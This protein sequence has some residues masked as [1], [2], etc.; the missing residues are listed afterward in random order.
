MEYSEM[1]VKQRAEYLLKKGVEAKMQIDPDRLAPGYAAHVVGIGM[2]SACGYHRS[3]QDAIEAGREYLLAKA[4]SPIAISRDPPI[5]CSHCW[6]DDGERGL[7]CGDKDWMASAESS[8]GVHVAACRRED[9]TMLSTP[10]GL[11]LLTCAAGEINRNA[12]QAGE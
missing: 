12:D 3:E 9:R 7:A 6:D 11:E 5:S 10:A 8:L 2:L 1:T 4:R